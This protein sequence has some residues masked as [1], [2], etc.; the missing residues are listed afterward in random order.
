[1]DIMEFVRIACNFLG[2]VGILL[3][4][5]GIL[6]IIGLLGGAFFN[7]QIEEKSRR[8]LWGIFWAGLI[9]GGILLL[10]PLLYSLY[11]YQ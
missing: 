1:M 11:F 8:T 6:A 10:I 3:I 2:C 5:F 4:F 9:V 7:L